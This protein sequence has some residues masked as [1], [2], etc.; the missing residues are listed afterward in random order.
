MGARAP[1]RGRPAPVQGPAQLGWALL[2]IAAALIGGLAAA[3]LVHASLVVAVI[4]SVVIGAIGVLV[5]F[6]SPARS[7]ELTAPPRPPCRGPPA[8]APTGPLRRP[9]PT[10]PTRS[11]P[12]TARFRLRAEPTG[13][14]AAERPP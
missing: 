7:P 4:V 6:R 11:A 2:V 5:V 13:W 3:T 12:V 8:P 14:T 9:A 1:D 10:R